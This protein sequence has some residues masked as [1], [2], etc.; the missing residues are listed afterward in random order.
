MC[1]TI[2]LAKS[3]ANYIKFSSL[4]KST[5]LVVPNTTRVEKLRL[6]YR[7]STAVALTS[8]GHS[9]ATL[10]EHLSFQILKEPRWLGYL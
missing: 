9:P 3:T 2:Q 1:G 6:H 5:E 4:L 7:L 10:S 8:T